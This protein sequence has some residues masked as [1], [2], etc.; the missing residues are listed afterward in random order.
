MINIEQFA[1]I[2]IQSLAIDLAK[3]GGG[4]GSKFTWTLA[5][6]RMALGHTRTQWFMANRNMKIFDKNKNLVASVAERVGND[7]S[8][9]LNEP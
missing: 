4:R 8:A 5:F 6:P 2:C 1:I 9:I 7:F 3:P